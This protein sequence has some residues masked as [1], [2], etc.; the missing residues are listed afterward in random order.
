[1]HAGGF[2]MNARHIWRVQDLAQPALLLVLLLLQSFEA[3]GG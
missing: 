1:M 2:S 3:H